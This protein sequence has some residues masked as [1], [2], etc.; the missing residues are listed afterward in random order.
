MSDKMALDDGTGGGP[1]ATKLEKDNKWFGEYNVL[2]RDFEAG[3]YIWPVTLALL[4]REQRYW[5]IYWLDRR[6]GF[7]VYH[8]W[9]GTLCLWCKDVPGNKSPR[10]VYKG[11]S[12]SGSLVCGLDRMEID[13]GHMA[14]WQMERFAD[15]VRS[16]L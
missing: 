16:I 14:T 1:A 7:S 3:N 9:E 13:Y 4:E 5:V 12:R 8:M 10:T 2:V 15:K 6:D 11:E